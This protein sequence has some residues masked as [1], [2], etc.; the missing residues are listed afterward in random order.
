MF[1]IAWNFATLL[2]LG[3]LVCALLM[4]LDLLWLKPRRLLTVKQSAPW[5]IV[6]AEAIFPVL[7]LVL[8]VR[9]FLFEPFRIP[10]GSMKPGLLEGD[11]ILVNKYAYGLRLPLLGTKVVSIGHLKRGDVVVFHAPFNISEDFIKRVV[12]LPGDRIEYKHKTVYIN[13]QPQLQTDDGVDYDLELH[14]QS[15]T[16]QKKTEYFTN[17]ISHTLFIR[18]HVVGQDMPAFVVPEGEYFM[19]GDNRDN[20]R[21]S[22]FWGLV[23]DKYIVGKAVRIWMSW[24]TIDKKIR[25]E[26]IGNKI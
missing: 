10:S 22:R 26:R 4:A 19:L 1:D 11:F 13:G 6:Q 9:S 23:K 16:V 7:L 3:V 18:P 5:L 24:D 8:C 21:D 12:G 15:Y 17:G 25:M 2:T 20:S 14:G